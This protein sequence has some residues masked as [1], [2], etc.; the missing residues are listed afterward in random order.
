MESTGLPFLPAAIK[1]VGLTEMSFELVVKPS[2]EILHVET[3]EK[4]K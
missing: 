4:N 3:L 2:G 1:A